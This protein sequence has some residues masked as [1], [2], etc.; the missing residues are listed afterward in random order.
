LRATE[1]F[2]LF[3]FLAFYHRV[4][5]SFNFLLIIIGSSIEVA[6]NNVFVN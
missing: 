3:A 1:S 2:A 6:V 4:S 5:L